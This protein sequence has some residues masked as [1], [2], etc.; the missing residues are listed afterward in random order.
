MIDLIFD[1]MHKPINVGVAVR[2]ACSAGSRLY[3][4]GSSTDYR[5]RKALLSAVGYEDVVEIRYEKDLKGLLEKLR[6]EGKKIIATS[7]RAEKSY[8]ASDYTVPAAILMGNE[9][10]GLSKESMSF[11]DELVSIPMPGGVESLNVV[12]SAAIILYEG[13]RQRGLV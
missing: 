8:T 6:G 10:T 5:N 12:T 11:A 9:A 7:P 4:T 13:L 1:N 2:L 3:F